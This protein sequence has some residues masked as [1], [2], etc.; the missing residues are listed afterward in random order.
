MLTAPAPAS[1]KALKRAGMKATDI[2]LWEINEAFA[3]GAAA[4]ARRLSI[5]PERGQRQ[6]RRH[7]P[8]PPAR[9]DRRRLLTRHRARRARAH[10]QGDRADHPLHRRRDGHR[11]DHRARL[12]DPERTQEYARGTLTI[13]VP[14][15]A[16]LTA[17][18]S[19]GQ[20]P[21]VAGDAKL[22]KAFRKT[23]EAEVMPKQGAGAAIVAFGYARADWEA[24]VDDEGVLMQEARFTVI[25]R[26]PDDAHRARCRAM[27][28]YARRDASSKSGVV[29]DPPRF[30]GMGLE[31]RWTPCPLAKK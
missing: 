19:A 17:A 28:L 2:D 27:A 7:R 4:D 10:R 8:R 12:S 3:V 23:V 31:T 1:E 15:Q 6:R 30:G 26:L 14:D 9:R 18:L 29:W 16:T 21:M 22:L 5:D 13:A 11:H 25:Y 24:T 20:E